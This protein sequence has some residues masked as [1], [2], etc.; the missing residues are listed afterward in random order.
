MN[1]EQIAQDERVAKI[2]NN[3]IKKS[4]YTLVIGAGLGVMTLLSP[5]LS[6][7][8]YTAVKNQ[9]DVVYAANKNT[10]DRYWDAKK[11]LDAPLSSIVTAGDVN[12]QKNILPILAKRDSLQ[13]I[14]DNTP[15]QLL[16]VYANKTAE[17]EEAK[18]DDKSMTVFLNAWTIF[19]ALGIF[20]S[21]IQLLNSYR[22]KATRILRDHL[23]Y[24]S[25]NELVY[26]ADMQRN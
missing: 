17:L 24:K 12:A 6:H 19:G 2:E 13:Q 25:A 20:S 4:L 21:T 9:L 3:Y 8:N 26:V 15:K 16:E 10:L 11:G 1:D 14:I 23:S 22:R 7:A 5:G 18:Q